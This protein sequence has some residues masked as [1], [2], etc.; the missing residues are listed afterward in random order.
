MEYIWNNKIYLPTI[1]Q[2]PNVLKR[3]EII[4]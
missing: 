2:T 3:E 4:H 1:E